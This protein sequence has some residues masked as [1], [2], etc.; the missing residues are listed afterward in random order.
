MEGSLPHPGPPRP[1]PLRPLDVHWPSLPRCVSP[2][3]T[4]SPEQSREAPYSAKGNTAS[5]PRF[6]SSHLTILPRAGSPHRE[7]P[8]VSAAPSDPLEWSDLKLRRSTQVVT[9]GRADGGNAKPASPA[10]PRGGGR[11]PLTTECPGLASLPVT[12]GGLPFPGL[13]CHA[14]KAVRNRLRAAP[15]RCTAGSDGVR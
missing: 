10:H 13:W 14:M 4:G 8:C 7:V 9:E 2:R 5:E 11:A 3:A 15:E 6:F 12:A 1:G